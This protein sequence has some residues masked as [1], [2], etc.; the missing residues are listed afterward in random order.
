MAHQFALF[1]GK[2]WLV[3]ALLLAAEFKHAGGKAMTMGLKTSVG[4]VSWP[5]TMSPMRVL[6]CRAMSVMFTG[7]QG[8]E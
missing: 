5:G 1:P 3:S 7:Y 6:L 8:A 4:E 2:Q